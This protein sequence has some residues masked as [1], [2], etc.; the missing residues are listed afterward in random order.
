MAHTNEQ[1]QVDPV[2]CDLDFWPS[3]C[4]ISC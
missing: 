1:T 3:I 4:S 2:S